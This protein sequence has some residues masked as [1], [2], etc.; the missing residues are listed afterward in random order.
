MSD[1]SAVTTFLF[2]D[3]EGSTRLWAEVP[4]RMRLAL[5][6]HDAITRTAIEAHRGSVTKMTGDGVHAAFTDPI[7]AIGAALRL[8]H[9]LSDPAATAGIP[10]RV[11]CGLHLGVAERR[12]ND[13]FGTTVN[14]AQH[15]MDAANGG[16]VLLS[17]AVA[18]LVSGRLPPNAELADLG[19]VRLRDLGGPSAST[20]SFTHRCGAPFPRCA[21]SRR[22]PTTCR[23]SSRPS[24]AAKA[25]SP[26]SSGGCTGTAS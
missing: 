25:N 1:A 16:Q 17:Q 23:N 12:D 19:S 22:S 10:L 3:I 24:S 2:A 4:E 5:A 7:D 13:Y 14:R 6:A 18:L 21:R 11:R 8:Q 9:A 15:V 20:S 26:T